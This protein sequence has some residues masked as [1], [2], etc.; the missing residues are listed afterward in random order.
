MTRLMSKLTFKLTFKLMPKSTST[1]IALQIVLVAMLLLTSCSS[2]PLEK[3]IKFAYTITASEDINLDINGT[4][5]SVIVRVFQLT[6]TANF[7]A[8]RYENVFT[9]LQNKLGAEFIGVNEHLVDPET[10]QVFKVDLSA[11]AKF[12]GIAVGYRS[13]DTVTWKTVQAIPEKSVFDPLG[14]FSREGLFISVEK[15]SVRVVPK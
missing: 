8:A 15:S 2:S 11:Q 4:P 5:S 13:A 12:L 14:F 7:K 9:G 6:N 1:L 10:E 3:K